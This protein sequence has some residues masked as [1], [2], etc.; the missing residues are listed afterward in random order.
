[1][2]LN[3]PWPAHGNFEIAW[4]GN[5]IRVVFR[6]VWN[7]EAVALLLERVDRLLGQPGAPRRWA[8]LADM[9]EWEGAT[10]DALSDYNAS[11]SVL[12]E[13]GMTAIARVFT[14]AFLNEMI[15]ARVNEHEQIPVLIT[16]N[17]DDALVWLAN[18]G[19]AMNKELK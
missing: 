2:A 11:S 19:F 16:E 14:V 9:R 13:R 15:K 6:G 7:R 1:M 4:H 12:V 5:V 3:G 8:A 17:M 10:P 18:Q